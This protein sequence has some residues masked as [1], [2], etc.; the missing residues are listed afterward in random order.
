MDQTVNLARDETDQTDQTEK[1][2]R[3]NAEVENF[4]GMDQ[5]VNLAR[6]E[7]TAVVNDQDDLKE[8]HEDEVDKTTS[9]VENGFFSLLGLAYLPDV[10][11]NICSNLDCKVSNTAKAAFYK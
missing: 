9:M 3:V 10:I 4:E 2:P 8:D 11:V 5:T 1:R 6:D 7:T